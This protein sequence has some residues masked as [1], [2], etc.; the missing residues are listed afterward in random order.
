VCF[1]ILLVGAAVAMIVVP[2]QDVAVASN[3]AQLDTIANASYE[4]E[5]AQLAEKNAAYAERLRKTTPYYR[6]LYFD[7]PL[8]SG[9]RDYIINFIPEDDYLWEAE[10]LQ[11]A[12]T[13]LK[14][15]RLLSQTD[16]YYRAL[17][18]GTMKDDPRA[19]VSVIPLYTNITSIVDDKV[20][21]HHVVTDNK[22]VE[23]LAKRN[24]HNAQV[25]ALINLYRGLYPAVVEVKEACKVV[26]VKDENRRE[27]IREL[28]AQLQALLA[29]QQAQSVQSQANTVGVVSA[30]MA[31]TAGSMGMVGSSEW[32][33]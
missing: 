28:E 26:E 14:H 22:E 21:Q 2:S 30:P 32:K 9:M 19:D 20:P 11:L 17:Y 18:F 31:S 5:V 1:S 3:V 10:I 33:S 8:A 23:E 25:V 24:L 4:K 27:Q 15:A 16:L 29:L 6:K 7:M 13:N 12:Q